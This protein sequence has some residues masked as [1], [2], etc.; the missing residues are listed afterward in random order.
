MATSQVPVLCDAGIS[1]SQMADVTQLRSRFI[2]QPSDGKIKNPDHGGKWRQGQ[3]WLLCASGF[4][5]TT[6]KKHINAAIQGTAAT[7]P[8]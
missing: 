1:E 4:P 8:D 6:K 5:S 2:W 7:I 3:A